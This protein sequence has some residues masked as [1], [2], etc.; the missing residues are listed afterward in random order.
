MKTALNDAQLNRLARD[1][2][3]SHVA[4]PHEQIQVTVQHGVLKLEGVVANHYQK[5]CAEL[6]V[7][8]LKH[9]RKIDNQLKIARKPR[10]VEASKRQ[11]EHKLNHFPSLRPGQINF[12]ID[13]H[14]V[15]L[16]GTVGRWQE[17]EEVE[18]AAL[19]TPGITTVNNNII[20]LEQP[21]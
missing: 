10:S 8:S 21:K 16:S 2:L 13:K 14:T 17:R 20:V 18:Q 5:R 3:K 1:Y 15:I 12:R 6:A 19:S 11:L 4:V 9:L 7:S